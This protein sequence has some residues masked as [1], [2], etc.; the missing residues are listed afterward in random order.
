M[1]TLNFAKRSFKELIRD[2][3]S[4]IFAIGL[5]VFLLFIF[6]QFKIPSAA[7]RIENFTA[8]ILIFGFAFITMFTATLVAK[9]RSTSL[10]IR[11]W[12]SPMK[13][14]DYVLGY[15][16]SLI[17]IVL[18]QN[19][20]FFTVGIALGLKF[21]FRVILASLASIPISLLFI[22]LGILIGSI[23]NEKSSAGVS[24]IIVQLVAFAGGMYFEGDMLGDFF[25][26]LCKALPFSHS[27]EI[28]RELI[29]NR[30]EKLLNSVITVCIYSAV[31]WTLSIWT[32][33]RN[34]LKGNN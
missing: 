19:S 17:P 34:M 13:S 4:I 3:L 9:D 16:L 10:L 5:P 12:I 18:L 2:P 32:F 21:S 8:G 24:S 11:L 27:T 23:T 14:T 30:G 1:R 22:A 25:S 15:A 6:T 33:K 29:N 28:L 31:I 7:Y 26:F 20:L